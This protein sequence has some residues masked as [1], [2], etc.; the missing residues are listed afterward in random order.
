MKMLRS[1][2]LGGAVAVGL[3]TAALS[4]G[5]W[6]GVPPLSGTQTLTGNEFAPFDTGRTAGLNPAT[7][8]MG[9]QQ[10][11]AGYSIVTTGTSGTVP[12]NVSNYIL[13]G[14][15]ATFAVTL[16]AAPVDGSIVS[17]SNPTSTSISTFSVSANTGQTITSVAPT[18]LGAQ[19]ATATLSYKYIYNAATA[20]WYR[21]Q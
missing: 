8:A 18:A 2:L 9:L 19:S 13:N 17:I 6:Q 20:V 14:V 11:G 7:I 12:N 21:L 16:P 1:L 5:F 10:L 4:A 3:V 15:G